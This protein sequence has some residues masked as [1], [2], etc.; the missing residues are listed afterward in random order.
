LSNLYPSPFT[1]D[2]VEYA[3]VEA[4]RMYIKY[5]EEYLDRE[6]I[7]TLSGLKAKLS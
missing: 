6:N 4:F 3:S 7:K 1:L 5:P 2:G